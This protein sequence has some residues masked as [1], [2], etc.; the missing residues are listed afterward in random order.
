MLTKLSKIYG[1]LW[2]LS[3]VFLVAAAFISPP[4][5]A[6]QLTWAAAML[7]LFCLVMLVLSRFEFYKQASESRKRAMKIVVCLLSILIVSCMVLSAWLHS[8]G[9]ETGQS[10]TETPPESVTE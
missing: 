3:F 6:S 1:Q 5:V 7:V 8:R 9:D 10:H 4:D 2:L